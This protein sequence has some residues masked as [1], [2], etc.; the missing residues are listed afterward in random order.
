MCITYI[1]FHR[2]CKAQGLD[3]KTL[4]YT[5]YFQPYCAWIALV[6]LV[7]VTGYYGYTAFIPFTVSGFFQS[8]AMQLFIPPLY[9]IWKLVKRTKVI[10]PQQADLVWERP[11]IDAYEATFI[12]EPN[13][14]WREML[15]LVGIKKPKA[16]VDQRRR[17]SIIPP[18]ERS[19]YPVNVAEHIHYD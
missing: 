14:F 4:P 13:G 11:I 15:Q 12:D 7:I 1:F 9:I 2:A 5:G 17:S 18:Q 3:R 6:W 10:K 16:G 8:Y 19:H